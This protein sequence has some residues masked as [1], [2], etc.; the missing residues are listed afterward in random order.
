M[1]TGFEWLTVGAAALSGVNQISQGNQQ[2]RFAE[3]Q[4][5]Q[6]E[7]D[8]QAERELG[9]VRAGQ[10]RK[11]GVRQVSEARAGFASAGVDVG[12]GTPL[13]VYGDI[14]QDAEAA[15][16][17]EILFGERKGAR[18]EQEAQAMRASGKNAQAQG[19]MGASGSVLAAGA[20]LT[21]PGWRHTQS[22]APVYEYTPSGVVR[23]S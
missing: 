12:T 2:R 15:A 11:S 18:L 6:A 21:K 16:L 23:I 22:P 20:T 1:C 19:W 14:T 9:Q 10:V 5:A 4:A 3:F 13:T 17:Q 7:A 8:A